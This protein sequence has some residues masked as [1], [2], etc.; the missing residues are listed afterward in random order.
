MGGAEFT[1][2][3]EINKT[4]NGL[5]TKKLDIEEIYQS[6]LQFKESTQCSG[7]ILHPI[8]EGSEITIYKNKYSYLVYEKRNLPFK[9]FPEYKLI[10]D[11]FVTMAYDF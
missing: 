1:V 10:L 3:Y 5:S 11:Q 8:F 2:V 7:K 6:L 9:S 4:V